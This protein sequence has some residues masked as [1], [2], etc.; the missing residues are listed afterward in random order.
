VSC[1][2]SSR[3]LATVSQSNPKGYSSLG[4]GL[5]CASLWAI[6]HT[7]A[8]VPPCAWGL[9]V[10]VRTCGDSCTA[11]SSLARLS[12]TVSSTCGCTI[13]SA[14]FADQLT[15]HTKQGQ[16]GRTVARG[17]V[18]TLNLQVGPPARACCTVS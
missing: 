1:C 6:S 14:P 17:A 12:L 16:A 4:Q 15:A 18:L 8:H 10:R 7:A 11:S 5:L 3:L 13:C 9:Q 2:H